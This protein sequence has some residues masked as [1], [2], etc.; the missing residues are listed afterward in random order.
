MSLARDD[1]QVQLPNYCSSIVLACYPENA[2]AEGVEKLHRWTSDSGL[3]LPQPAHLAQ[4]PFRAVLA[5]APFRAHVICAV[6]LIMLECAPF[7]R[8]Q[9]D[10]QN[11]YCH[12]C[13]CQFRE[14]S[15]GRHN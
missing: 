3:V 8:V 6:N 11:E 13:P 12:L 15:E 7:V 10:N 4:F 5:H 9:K 14:A 1:W 2:N